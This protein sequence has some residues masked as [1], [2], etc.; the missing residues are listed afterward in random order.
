M[1]LINCGAKFSHNIVHF[2]L[3]KIMPNY[4]FHTND[5]HRGVTQQVR[6]AGLYPAGREFESLHPY[7]P[8]VAVGSSEKVD[9]HLN[10]CHQ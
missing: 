8:I 3:R 5:V 2:L 7:Q 9:T 10:Y 4:W 1:P 6:V